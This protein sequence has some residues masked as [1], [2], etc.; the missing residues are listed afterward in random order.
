[1]SAVDMLPSQLPA[2]DCAPWCRDG[3]GHV[4][5]W[6]PSDQRCD[7]EG[8]VIGLSKY[9][10]VKMASAEQP[11]SLDWVEVH[12]TRQS[13]GPTEIHVLREAEDGFM[14]NLTPAEAKM[15]GAALIAEA[16][17]AI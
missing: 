9:P 4:D 10:L 16:E 11:R 6:H 5:E 2:V 13:D 14:L 17:R 8:E 15:L 3:K 1:M 7:S 12:L